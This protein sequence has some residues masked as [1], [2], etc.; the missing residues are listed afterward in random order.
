MWGLG[1]GPGNFRLE[2]WAKQFQAGAGSQATVSC[3]PSG[4]RVWAAKWKLAEWEN[5]FVSRCGVWPAAQLSWSFGVNRKQ[6]RNNNIFQESHW[7]FWDGM[8]KVKMK[9]TIQVL[10]LRFLHSLVR[11]SQW[12][13]HYS[14]CEAIDGDSVQWQ[15]RWC[16][17]NYHLWSSREPDNCTGGGGVTANLVLNQLQQIFCLQATNY[18]GITHT[19]VT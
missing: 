3:L 17:L 18:H 13:G 6:I 10:V 2:T 19:W 4:C 11:S 1:L 12:K 16:P 15:M 14:S 8:F 5:K 7:E 9:W